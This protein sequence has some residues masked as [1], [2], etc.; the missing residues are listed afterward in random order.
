MCDIKNNFFYEFSNK[1]Y[2]KKPLPHFQNN[3]YIINKKITKHHFF[4][5]IVTTKVPNFL[6]PTI[7]KKH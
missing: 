1:E 5:Y 7:L 6:I 4:I 2:F 3:I